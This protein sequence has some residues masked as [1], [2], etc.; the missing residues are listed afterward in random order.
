LSQRVH[1]SG[2]QN[3]RKRGKP[4]E[5]DLERIGCKTKLVFISSASVLFQNTIEIVSWTTRQ[6]VQ[7]R[8]VGL[9]RLWND[10]GTDVRTALDARL[11]EWHSGTRSHAGAHQHLGSVGAMGLVQQF[12][13]AAD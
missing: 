6:V 8:Y 11:V 10:G 7:F 2:H 12:L 4:D 1:H 9:F 3:Q 13:A 5:N